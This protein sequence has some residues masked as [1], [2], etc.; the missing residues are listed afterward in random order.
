MVF[1]IADDE[2]GIW[3]SDSPLLIEKVQE[4][5]GFHPSDDCEFLIND[6]GILYMWN[7]RSDIKGVPEGYVV[8]EYRDEELAELLK[9]G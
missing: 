2:G 3:R 4:E 6:T 9:K 8:L 1:A 5:L 7:G